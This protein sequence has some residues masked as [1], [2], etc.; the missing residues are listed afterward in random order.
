MGLLSILLSSESV[1]ML[2]WQGRPSG[3]H[4]QSITSLSLLFSSCLSCFGIILSIVHEIVI[5]SRSN[6]SDGIH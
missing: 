5:K 4:L 6:V 3:L 1:E 2:D